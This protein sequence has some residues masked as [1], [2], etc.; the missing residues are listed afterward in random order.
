VI[1]FTVTSGGANVTKFGVTFDDPGCEVYGGIVTAT[2]LYPIASG[3]FTSTRGNPA[4]SGSFDSATTAR[5]TARVTSYESD[6]CGDL[7]L[8]T[9]TW[10]AT[11]HSAS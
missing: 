4:F 5:G 8:E 9:A 10:T 2:S 7:E 11:W 1:T 6:V 3:S